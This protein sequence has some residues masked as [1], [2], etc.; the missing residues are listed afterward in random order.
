VTKYCNSCEQV[1]PVEEFARNSSR[2]DGLQV[3]CRTCKGTR[4]RAYH[5]AVPQRRAPAQRVRRAALR[6]RL[7]EYMAERTCADCPESDPVVME[8]DHVRGEKKANVGDLLARGSGWPAMLEEIGK[9]E[10]V[11]ANCHRRRTA[12]RGNHHRWAV[13]ELGRPA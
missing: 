1:K 11:C 6:Q 10:M 2:R 7:Y 5:S 9:C 8:F 3:E 12:R 4:D 13:G